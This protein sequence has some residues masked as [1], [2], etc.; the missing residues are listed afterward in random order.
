MTR[1]PDQ[2]GG[3]IE[4]EPGL[5]ADNIDVLQQRAVAA[6]AAN[7]AFLA[8]GAPTNAQV[9]AQTQRLTRECTAVI[10]LLLNQADDTSGT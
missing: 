1:V 9:L 6:I 4:L 3:W 8:I 10:R 5:R 2:W 7:V